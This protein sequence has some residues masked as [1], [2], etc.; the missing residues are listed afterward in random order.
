[1]LITTHPIRKTDISPIL[2]CNMGI[3][4]E[5]NF[6]QCLLSIGFYSPNNFL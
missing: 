3:M 2:K 1:M 4:L 6:T 5:H